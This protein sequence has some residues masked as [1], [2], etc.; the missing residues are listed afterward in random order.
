MFCKRNQAGF[1]V[2]YGRD[3][4]PATERQI[5]SYQ[6]SLVVRRDQKRL[7]TRGLNTYDGDH[8]GFEYMTPKLRLQASDLPQSLLRSRA[9]HL[10][11]SPDR[12]E[13][14]I[15][16]LKSFRQEI[17]CTQDFVSV[18]EPVPDACVPER[19]SEFVSAMSKVSV[20]SP[21]AEE[22]AG[23]LGRPPSDPIESLADE[24]FA[25]HNGIVIIRCSARGAYVRSREVSAW[26]PASIHST[27]E[28]VD[29]TGA[30]NTFC[31]ALA[32]C[33]GQQ[34]DLHRAVINASVAAGLAIAQIGLP[35]LTIQDGI[36]LWNG[37]EMR[38]LTSQYEDA[39]A[40]RSNSVVVS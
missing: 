13:E 31:G 34:M 6:F 21:N 38:T 17:G 11:C 5:E 33:L 7:C 15:S 27:A 10:I 35:Q 36:E 2:D 30:G 3:I 25:E 22:A 28:V 29:A 8:R 12:C 14:I 16:N 26:Y 23:I 19:W 20:L 24:L 18:W 9:F 40:R 32:V 4:E 37:Q 1:I 39:L